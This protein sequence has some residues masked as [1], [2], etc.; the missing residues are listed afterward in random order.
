MDITLRTLLFWEN[1][2]LTEV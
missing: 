1:L 2:R